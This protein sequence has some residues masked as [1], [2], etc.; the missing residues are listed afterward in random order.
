[1]ALK[2]RL[3]FLLQSI[4]FAL[5]AYTPAPLVRLGDLKCVTL[6]DMQRCS[7]SAPF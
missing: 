3:I 5:T 6:V 1:M 2:I 4:H 7:I